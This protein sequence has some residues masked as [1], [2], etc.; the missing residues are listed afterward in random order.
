M[1]K[2]RLALL[3]I[4][5]SFLVIGIAGCGFLGEPEG[6]ISSWT[7]EEQKGIVDFFTI[8]GEVKNVGSATGGCFIDGRIY[9]S[10]DV[11]LEE[12]TDFV[13]GLKAGE[14]GKFEIVFMVNPDKVDHT[15]VEVDS[16][17][18]D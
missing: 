4:L 3:L 12:L 1:R 11:L 13:S 10:S 17:Y 9:N 6:E 16:C 15:E 2:A 18:K 7:T 14:T 8:K 5:I